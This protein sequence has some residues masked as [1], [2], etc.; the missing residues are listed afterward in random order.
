MHKYPTILSNSEIPCIIRTDLVME[1]PESSKR[2]YVWSRDALCIFFP[3]R[4][5]DATTRQRSK[6]GTENINTGINQVDAWLPSK[7][8]YR[9]AM[10]ARKN[11]MDWDPESPRKSFAGWEFK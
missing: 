4:K 3:R 10:A 9:I 6:S 7:G 11:P 8:W 1:K 2:W 5:R